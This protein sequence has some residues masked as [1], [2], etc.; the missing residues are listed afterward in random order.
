VKEN[1]ILII[2]AS[3]LVGSNCLNWFRQ[4]EGFTAEGTYFSYAAPGTYYYDTLNPENK[5]NYDVA[6][7]R[8]T[9]ILH[10][11]ALT[12]VDYCEQHPEESYEKT[13]VSTKNV[14]AL[15]KQQHAAIIYVSTDYVFNGESGPYVETDK[16]DPISVYA[17]HKLEAE[18]LVQASGLSYIIIRITNVYGDELRNKNFVARLVQ[19]AGSNEKLHLKLPYDQYATPANAADIAKALH[20]LIRDGKTGIYHIASTDYLNR[21]QLAEKVL[22]HAGRGEITYEVLDTATLQQPAKRPL[23]GGLLSH[24]FL[25][26][27][28]E[29]YFSSVDEY[30]ANK[31]KDSK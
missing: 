11:G 24:K 6:A 7:F 29:F 8:P 10:A 1:R 16:V 31:L 20:L 3:G 2:G 27:Y 14:I 17:R 9:H 12:H 28:P 30:L 21:V 15:A 18:Q 26:E 22:R 4:Q 5:E 13:V 25:K 19:A 23:N